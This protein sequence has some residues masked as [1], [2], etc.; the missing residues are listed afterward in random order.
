MPS[1]TTTSRVEIKNMA[2]GETRCVEALLNLHSRLVTSG[3]ER[4]QQ[5]QVPSQGAISELHPL[6]SVPVL[7]SSASDVAQSTFYGHQDCVQ[8]VVQF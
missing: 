5:E 8:Y 6:T 7:A 3:A 1:G 2:E 4:G